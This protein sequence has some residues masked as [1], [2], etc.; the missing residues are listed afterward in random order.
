MKK[1]C[2]LYT[3]AIKWNDNIKC[4]KYVDNVEYRKNRE[5]WVFFYSETC[6]P[7]GGALPSESHWL[8]PPVYHPVLVFFPAGFM[9]F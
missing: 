5:T 1:L 8:A 9:F 3:D 4:K 2:L 7:N 6:E